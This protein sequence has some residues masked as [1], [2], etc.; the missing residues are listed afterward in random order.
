MTPSS[1][2]MLA[3]RPRLAEVAL[4]SDPFVGSEAAILD[5]VHIGEPLAKVPH[6]L[7]GEIALEPGGLEMLHACNLR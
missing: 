4:G 2:V 7:A 6:D 1:E 5:R 3:R